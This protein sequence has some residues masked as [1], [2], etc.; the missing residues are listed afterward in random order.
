MKIENIPAG[1]LPPKK[2][3]AIIEVPEDGHVKYEIDKDT[4]LLKVDRILHTPLAYPANY[5][6]FPGTL[7]DDGDPL[8]CVVVCNAPLRPGVLIEVRPIGVLLMEDQAGRDEKIIC[9]PRDKIDPYYTK[10]AFVEEL[11]EILRSK[12]EYFFAHYK[13]LEPNSWSKILGWADRVQADKI[14]M[15]SIDR[16]WAKKRDQK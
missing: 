16:Y 7:G 5:G 4:G 3:N 15:E 13:D 11:P 2:M 12:I 6:Y 8:D 14:I 1:N 9:V 10:I